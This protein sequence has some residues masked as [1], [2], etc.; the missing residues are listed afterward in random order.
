MFHRKTKRQTQ[1]KC[2]FYEH[3]ETSGWMAWRALSAPVYCSSTANK[4]KMQQCCFVFDIAS[5]VFCWY[6]T[7][8]QSTSK[9]YFYLNLQNDA[10]VSGYEEICLLNIS[11]WIHGQENFQLP[12]EIHSHCGL[13]GGIRFLFELFDL[14]NYYT[15]S[16]KPDENKTDISNRYERHRPPVW[17]PGDSW[18]K[19]EKMSEW[20]GLQAQPSLG[21]R[22][23]A[24]DPHHH[25]PVRVM[26]VGE[27]LH[28]DLLFF[29]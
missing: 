17:N 24:D 29:P 14:L 8:P 23:T 27:W 4:C 18:V 3:K 20:S 2:L 25:S 22:G 19:N 12:R 16:S 1:W 10:T 28:I 15:K 7:S 6:K 11:K 13:T 9:P 5:C 26:G 21:L